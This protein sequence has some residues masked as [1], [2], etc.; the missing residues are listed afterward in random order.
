MLI[1]ITDSSLTGKLI[2]K[3][4]LSF[5]SEIVIVKD[6]IERRVYDEVEAYNLKCGEVF[7][8][9]VEPSDCEKLLNG[10]K[11]RKPKL[12]DPEQQVYVALDAFQ[13]NGYFVL[14]DDIQAESLEQEVQLK[15]TTVVSFVKLTQLV[16]G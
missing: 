7:Y 4:Q 14:V 2:G 13:K 6:I 15:T 9:L 12:I 3:K 5:N 8:G 10:Y 1:T 11:M 16:G